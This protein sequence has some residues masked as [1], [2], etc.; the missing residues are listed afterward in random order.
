MLWI[1]GFWAT[2]SNISTLED[3]KFCYFLILSRFLLI[4]LPYIFLLTISFIERTQTDLS[5]ALISFSVTNFLLSWARKY[6]KWTIFDIHFNDH[7]CRSKHDNYKNDLF[8]H[9]LFKLYPLVYFIFAFQD[10]QNSVPTIPHIDSET[11]TPPPKF[12][13]VCKYLRHCLGTSF[14]AAILPICCNIE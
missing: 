4:F 1:V 11:N 12:N 7:D 5:G 3:T 14:S 6:K 10:L 13:V 2:F 8:F 9:R